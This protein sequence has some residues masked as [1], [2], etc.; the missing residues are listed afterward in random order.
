M[1]KQIIVFLSCLIVSFNLWAKDAC[2]NPDEYTV[3]K[4]CYVT[5]EQKKEKPYNAVVA[6]VDGSGVYCTG[7]IISK[8]NKLYLYTAKHCT[9]LNGD[10]LSDSS[11]RIKTQKGK[12]LTVS[13]NNVGSNNLPDKGSVSSKGDWA[14]Y[15]IETKDLDSVNITTNKKISDTKKTNEVYNAAYDTRVVGY[16]LLKIMSDAEIQ[17][18]KDNYISWLKKNGFTDEDINAV[19]GL[20]G[21]IS[22][23]GVNVGNDI[24]SK[25]IEEMNDSNFNRI[26]KDEKLKQSRCKYVSAST[27]KT[28]DKNYYFGCQGFGGNSGGGLFD[29]DG[30]LM[31][32]ASLGETAVGS[33][34]HGKL[35]GSVSVLQPKE[36]KIEKVKT[37]L[38]NIF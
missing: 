26:F 17:K 6:L 20:F 27:S 25:Y 24:V 1:I 14:I 8:D 5:D 28:T 30:N 10:K 35:I 21:V 9:D 13:K 32:I 16:G 31:A 4:R 2:T 33:E 36:T 3:D 18:F 23:S 29:N 38:Q 37:V 34:H 19:P 11:L 7:T 15:D 12:K 22:G